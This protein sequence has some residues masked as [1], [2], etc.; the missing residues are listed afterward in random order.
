MAL[1]TDINKFGVTFS[2]AYVKISACNYVNAFKKVVT[3]NELDMTDP[4][5]PIPVPPTV[6]CEKTKKIEFS[7]M[8]YLSQNS[9]EEQAESI[10]TKTY[11]FYVPAEETSVDILDLC[12]THLKTLSEFNNAIDA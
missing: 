5:N 3:Q 4:E 11:G 8:T 6:T 9:F 10:D 1:I 12:Y 2:N 7:T